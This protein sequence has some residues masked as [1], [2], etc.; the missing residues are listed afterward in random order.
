M[1]IVDRAILNAVVICAMLVVP[2]V[3]ACGA[4]TSNTTTKADVA[5]TPANDSVR[6]RRIMCI[7]MAGKYIWYSG[8]S[9]AFLLAARDI[10][11]FIDRNE[12]PKAN[13]TPAGPQ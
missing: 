4:T 5:E 3:V 1:I 7:N 2:V 8:D 11:N 6:Q 13:S 9:R 12:V 10:C